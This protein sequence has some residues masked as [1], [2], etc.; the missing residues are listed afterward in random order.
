[1]AIDT[2]GTGKICPAPNRCS[3]Q[4]LAGV[5]SAKLADSAIAI[6]LIAN[7][8]H[9]DDVLTPFITIRATARQSRAVPGPFVNLFYTKLIG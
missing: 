9:Y 2:S 4:A 3:N 1:L 6:L 7:G 5:A 8:F